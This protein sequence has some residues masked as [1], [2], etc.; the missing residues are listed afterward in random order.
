MV[1]ANAP[2]RQVDEPELVWRIRYQLTR[3]SASLRNGMASRDT[4]TR[5]TAEQLAAERIVGGALGSYEVLSQAPLPPN[6]DLFSAA[7]YRT[8]AGQ[9]PAINGD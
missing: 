2:M 1:V 9:A 5:R 8:G 3:L 4:Q 7:A 6:T